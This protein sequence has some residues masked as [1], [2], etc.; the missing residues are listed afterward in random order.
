MPSAKVDGLLDALEA[1]D[2]GRSPEAFDDDVEACLVGFGATPETPSSLEA[3]ADL[4]ARAFGNDDLPSILRALEADGSDFAAKA[5]KAMTKGS[6]A[7]VALSLELI[8]RAKDLS[9]DEV[10]KTDF[11]LVTRILQPP[12]D[13]APYSDFYEGVRAALVDKDRDPKWNPP[14]SPSDI[15]HHFS[16]LDPTVELAL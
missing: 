10:L 16:H 1:L 7:S 11:R 6:P 9:L 15:Q 14:L 4:I 8:K 2:G 5:A 3:N 12:A 13:G